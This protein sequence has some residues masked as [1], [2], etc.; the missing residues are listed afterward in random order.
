MALNQ[1]SAVSAE[2]ALLLGLQS[3]F[4]AAT[5]TGTMTSVI[6]MRETTFVIECYKE[7]EMIE[8]YQDEMTRSF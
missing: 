4:K 8:E 1:G 6:R 7:G 5:A 2:S 3:E